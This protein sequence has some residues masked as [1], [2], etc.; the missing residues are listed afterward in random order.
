MDTRDR[1]AADLEPVVPQEDWRY[2]PRYKTRLAVNTSGSLFMYNLSKKQWF[3]KHP[4]T[5]RNGQFAVTVDGAQ[6]A[7]GRIAYE[8]HT[9][10]SVP[11]NKQVR[12]LNED[13]TD[14]RRENLVVANQSIIVNQKKIGGFIRSNPSTG[15]HDVYV[16]RNYKRVYEGSYDTHCLAQ[17]AL[18]AVKHVRVHST[19]QSV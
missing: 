15:K 12:Y 13:S 18:D 7:A 10:K 19:Q 4:T 17:K 3:R 1:E 2:H 5:F 16:V 11:S 14:L 9:G 6:R 8:C